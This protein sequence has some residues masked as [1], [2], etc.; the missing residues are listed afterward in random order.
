MRDNGV[1]QIEIQTIYTYE[2]VSLKSEFKIKTEKRE[3]HKKEWRKVL[4]QIKN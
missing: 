3:I 1:E 2:Y 4:L